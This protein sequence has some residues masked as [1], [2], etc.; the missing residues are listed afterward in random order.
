MEAP[1]LQPVDGGPDYYGRF[2]VGLPDDPSYFPTGVWMENILDVPDLEK[3]RA[4][5]INT[6]VG[7]TEDSIPANLEGFNAHFLATWPEEGSEGFLVSD[8]ADMWAGPGDAAWTGKYPGHGEICD[9]AGSQCGYTVQ[10]ELSA[11]AKPDGILRYANYG[12]G[13][14][15]W[16]S[17]EEASVFVNDFQDVVSADNYWFT[18]PNICSLHEGGQLL[19]SPRDL[20]PSECRLAANY[21]WT[22][23]RV[24]SLISPASSKP[25]WG[26]VEV[27]HPLLSQTL[28]P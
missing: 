2:T 25:V 8:E 18:D 4:N 28:R 19:D 12:K 15:F 23:D 6:Y 1:R 13:V 26:F 3:D 9:P 14:T 27:G 11:A 21:G 5:G 22:V 16:E 7:I 10:R 20:T 17:D 24:R